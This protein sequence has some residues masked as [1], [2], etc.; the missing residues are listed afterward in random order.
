MSGLPI[1]IFQGQLVVPIGGFLVPVG[2]LQQQLQQPIQILTCKFC[3][4]AF[5]TKEDC[6][7]TTQASCNRHLSTCPRRIEFE[8]AKQRALA[9][10]RRKEEEAREERRRA[11]AAKAKVAE[12]QKGLNGIQNAKF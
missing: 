10:Q 2:S 11:D 5:E 6:F 3:G 8:A 7:C 1:F 9:E 12:L 4:E